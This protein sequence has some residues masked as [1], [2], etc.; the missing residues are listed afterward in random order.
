M[1]KASTICEKGGPVCVNK[2]K[3]G[4]SFLEDKSVGRTCQQSFKV[5]LM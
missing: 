5:E 4:E 1:L 3:V 2:R